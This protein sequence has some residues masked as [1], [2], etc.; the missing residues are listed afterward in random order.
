MSKELMVVALGVW[1]IIVPNLGIPSSWRMITLLITGLALVA[2]GLYLRA[3]ASSRTRGEGQHTFIE[4]TP[5][6]SMEPT[7]DHARKE[8]IHSLN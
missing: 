8:R 3:T 7:S 6:A 5:G 2:L 4:N 1:V